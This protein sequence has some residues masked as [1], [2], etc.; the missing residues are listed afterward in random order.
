MIGNLHVSPAFV[1]SSVNLG[2]EG[3]ITCLTQNSAPIV[4]SAL[5]FLTGTVLL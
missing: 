2:K 4:A 3:L 1:L 5:L